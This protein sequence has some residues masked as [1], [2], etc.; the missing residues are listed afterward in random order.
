MFVLW[1]KYDI[2]NITILLGDIVSVAWEN[3]KTISLNILNTIAP[4]KQAT[5]EVLSSVRKR[6]KVLYLFRYSKQLR[7]EAQLII[8]REQKQN[9]S[10]KTL[11]DTKM[12]SNLFRNI[13]KGKVCH[14]NI[15]TQN[16]KISD[17]R[18]TVNYVLTTLKM[19]KLSTI[20]MQQLHPILSVNC[21]HLL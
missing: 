7:N 1:K 5:A 11:E 4:I 20:L 3:L 19:R 6:D 16:L 12:T 18:L 14:L 9:T 21:L 2:T 13:L 15:M 10:P 17:F 8:L